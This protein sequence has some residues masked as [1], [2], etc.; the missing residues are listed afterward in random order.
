MNSYYVY[1]YVR[2]DT[3]TYFY[4]GKG[5]KN[6][7]FELKISRSSHFKN[8][9]ETIPCAV[10][11]IK[12]NLTSE[13]AYYEEEK[14]IEKLVFEE[15]YS[16]SVKGIKR[17]PLCHLVNKCWGG[18]GNAGYS[19]S[20]ETKQKMSEFHTGK[21]LSDETK[22]KLSNLNKGENHPQYGTKHSEIT[23]KRISESLKGKTFSEE[24]RKNLSEAHK[25]IPNLANRR[26]VKCIELDM[27]FN[28]ISEANAYMSE[29]YG[30]KKLKISEVCN[31]KRP[32]TGKLKDGTKLHWIYVD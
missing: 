12:D 14:M 1:G 31:G 26:K 6:R 30:Y 15:G 13:E 19:H 10:E 32:Y 21:K 29:N 9:V 3:N 4:I 20:E 8:I 7:C 28:S 5:K 24:R 23:R 25:G 11:I 27:I 22:Q 16:I 18:L 17:N 2:L